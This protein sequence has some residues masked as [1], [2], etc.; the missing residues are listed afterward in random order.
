MGASAVTTTLAAPLRRFYRNV[1]KGYS[2][3]ANG[4][5]ELISDPQGII[6]LPKG[7]NYRIV[8][9]IGRKMSDSYP[10]PTA[11]DGM[12]AFAGENDTTIL[13]RNHELSPFDPLAVQGDP[14][15]KYD[16][17]CKGG[18]KTVILAKNNNLLQE[19]VSLNGTNRNCAGGVTP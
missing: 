16:K 10:V 11:F 4:F 1:A 6:D 3:Y 8:S 17:R 18:T 9:Q 13:I 14:S 15:K 12:A 5:G 7:F 2:V 19:F